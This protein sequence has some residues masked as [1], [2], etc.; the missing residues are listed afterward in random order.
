MEDPS[1]P[2]V[3]TDKADYVREALAWGWFCTE[4]LVWNG[5]EHEF[6]I[7]CRACEADRPRRAQ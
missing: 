1:K 2:I 3:L 6:L 7:R 4:C 5:D